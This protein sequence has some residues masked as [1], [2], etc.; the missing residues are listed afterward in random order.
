MK[1]FPA[2]TSVIHYYSDK[3]KSEKF[4]VNK[5]K[6][7]CGSLIYTEN[8]TFHFSPYDH[9][10]C[11]VILPDSVADSHGFIVPYEWSNVDSIKY[12]LKYN[13]AI[14]KSNEWMIGSNIY[15]KDFYN[16]I[17]IDIRDIKIR[18]LEDNFNIK[19]WEVY[20]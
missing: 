16:T 6:Q 8:N 3:T 7:H 13:L 20:Y 11:R 9:G 15:T 17:L 2:Y 18:I 19:K 14:E 5:S 4:I 12:M 10:G 1:N